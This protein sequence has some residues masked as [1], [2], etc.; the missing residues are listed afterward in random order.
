MG[1]TLAPKL[2]FKLQ[3]DAECSVDSEALC[4]ERHVQADYRRRAE[5]HEQRLPFVDDSGPGTRGDADVLCAFIVRRLLKTHF[6]LDPVLHAGRPRV[7][8]GHSGLQRVQGL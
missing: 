8:A 6:V 3:K 5:R 4:C 1:F 2:D 7:R